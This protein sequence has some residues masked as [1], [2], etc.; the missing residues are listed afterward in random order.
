MRRLRAVFKNIEGSAVGADSE[1]DFKGL[2]D[3]LEVNSHKLGNTVA[4]R[5]EK[6]VKL[7]DAIGDLNLGRLQRPRDR[8][9]RRRLRIPY[10]HVRLVAPASPAVS[11]SRRRRSLSC[12]PASPSSARVGQQGL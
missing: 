2:F 10:D 3:D 8:L 11:S 9:V 1:D 5:N 12:S 7:L 4:K 6:L